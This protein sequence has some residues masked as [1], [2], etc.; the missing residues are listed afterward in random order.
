MVWTEQDHTYQKARLG[1]RKTTNIFRSCTGRM[2]GSRN[3]WH[4]QRSACASSITLNSLERQLERCQLFLHQFPFKN[5]SFVVRC[6]FLFF[7]TLHLSL[8]D[9]LQRGG[10]GPQLVPLLSRLLRLQRT[11]ISSFGTAP[12]SPGDDPIKIF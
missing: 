9:H 2:I 1:W 12:D 11:P 3:S 4:F 10:G 8:L 7:Q 5:L 6:C